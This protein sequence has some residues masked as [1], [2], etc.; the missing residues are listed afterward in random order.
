MKY[1][2]CCQKRCLVH[3][4]EIRA[5]GGCYCVCRLMDH[6]RMLERTI[7]GDVISQCIIFGDKKSQQDYYERNKE[8]CDKWKEE[9]RER[10]KEAREELKNYENDNTSK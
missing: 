8:E 10:L 1:K 7:S 9:A 5:S 4:C 6:I 2:P 3:A